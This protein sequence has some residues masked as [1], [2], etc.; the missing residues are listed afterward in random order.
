MD[1]QPPT[2]IERLTGADDDFVSFTDSLS[3]NTGRAYA[4]ANVFPSDSDAVPCGVS[5]SLGVS[6]MGHQAGM[7][8]SMTDLDE[9]I[10]LLT[11]MRDTVNSG[12]AHFEGRRSPISGLID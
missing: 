6:N 2:R 9:L 1:T 10:A 8:L 4:V 7:D 5:I 12:V 3:G 11:E